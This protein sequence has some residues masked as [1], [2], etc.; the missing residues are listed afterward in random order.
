MF[1]YRLGLRLGKTVGEL[2]TLLTET[3]LC[4]WAAFSEM[5]PWGEDAEDI[6]AAGIAHTI[7]TFCQQTT[8]P[9]RFKVEQFLPFR[10]WSPPQRLSKERVI[11]MLHRVFGTHG[12]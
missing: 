7:A 8:R 11:E 6:R 12:R 3:E 1:L 10:R 5:W 2:E 9:K 4:E